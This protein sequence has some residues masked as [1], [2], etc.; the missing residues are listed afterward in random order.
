M[1]ILGFLEKFLDRVASKVKGWEKTYAIDIRVSLNK[2]VSMAAHVIFSIR[3]KR[4]F[5][6]ITQDDAIAPHTNKKTFT[7]MYTCISTNS[8]CCLFCILFAG[9]MH[10]RVYKGQSSQM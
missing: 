5:L 8:L 9:H 6:S 7:C 1:E 10:G 3:V 2:S 4:S